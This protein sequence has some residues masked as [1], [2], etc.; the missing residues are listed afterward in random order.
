MRVP[1]EYSTAL[2]YI[3]IAA[4]IFALLYFGGKGIVGLVIFSPSVEFTIDVDESFSENADYY[5]ELE[6]L[7]ILQGL[8]VNGEFVGAGKAR[9]YLERPEGNL[10]ILDTSDVGEIVEEPVE[11][12]GG[13]LITG[14]VIS[15]LGTESGVSSLESGEEELVEE[16][17][18]APAEESSPEVS[19][20]PVEESAE[21]EE[22]ASESPAEESPVEEVPNEDAPVEEPVV[23]DTL[24]ESGEEASEP[25][26]E[27]ESKEV[28]E[29][30]GDETSEAPSI[31][32]DPVEEEPEEVVDVPSEELE[33][34]TETVEESPGENI[35]N[36]TEEPI[37]EAGNETESPVEEPIINETEVLV[38]NETEVPTINE[39]EEPDTADS[40][41]QTPDSGGGSITPIINDTE[42]PTINETE[43]NNTA[44]SGLQTPD[45]E[46]PIIRFSDEC[47]ETCELEMN[48]SGIKL[49]IEIEGEGTL[50]L[51]SIDYIF[52]TMIEYVQPTL[53]QNIPDIIIEQNRSFSLILS[54]YF[55]GTNLSYTVEQPEGIRMQIESGKVFFNPED[56]FTGSEK[57]SIYASNIQNITKSNEFNIKVR[58]LNEEPLLNEFVNL[59]PFLSFI[60]VTEAGKLYTI[61]YEINDT[62][63]RIK[64]I[65]NATD[66]SDITIGEVEEVEL[67]I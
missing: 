62:I 32:E 6:D 3:V 12:I 58:K 19:E 16:T 8:D 56:G 28:V 51:T 24:E 2:K 43:S 29:E 66:L 61:V 36:E 55:T 63:V 26:V 1:K 49:I 47:K 22:D 5:V 17:S 60:E 59:F 31:E 30:S 23:E 10:L 37:V 42:T 4:A 52:Q 46:N 38:I 35:I 9:V 48:A 64:G 21:S 25:P 27:E 7:G 54:D 57:A 45:P 15:D 39:T 50:T 13:S 40:G 53:I 33:A 11:E 65:D 14:N 34:Q 67:N 44:D 20:S 18:E 41:L